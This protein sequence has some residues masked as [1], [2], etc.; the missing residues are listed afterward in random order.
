MALSNPPGMYDGTVAQMNT[1]R[2]RVAAAPLLSRKI[3]IKEIAL[4][5]PRLNLVMD[6]NGRANWAFDQASGKSDAGGA[7]GSSDAAGYVEGVSLAPVVIEDGDIKYLDERTGSV[8]AASGVNLTVSMP[9][10]QSPLKADGSLVWNRERI[11]MTLFVKDPSRLA[12]DGSPVDMTVNGRLLEFIFN[13]RG[14]LRNG[15]SLAGKIDMKTSSLRELAKWSGNPMDT[16]KGLETFSVNGALDLEGESIKLTKARLALD[17]MNAQGN[18]GVSLA[19]AR[20][21]ITANLGADK[22]D[23]NK[24]APP[25]NRGASTGAVSEGW[26]DEPISFV[27]LRA[28]DADLNL[29]VSQINYGDVVIGRTNVKATLKAGVLTATLKEMAFYD[30]KAEGKLVLNGK[31]AKPTLQG[32]LNSTGLDGY[33]LLADFAKLERISGVTGMNL[34]IAA[35]GSSQREMVSTMRGKGKFQ[36]NDGALRGI[37][38]ARMIRSV[39]EN[40]LGGWESKPEE[41]TDFSLLEASFDIKDGIAV[42]KDLKL[43]GPL[44][45]ITGLGEVDLLRQA[46]DYKTNPKLVATLQ[47]QGNESELAGLAVPVIIKGPWSNPKIYPDIEG[48][49][50]N[51]EAAFKALSKLTKAGAG[52]D[53]SK[54]TKGLEKK[55]KKKGLDKVQK[56]AK[57]L[58][59]EDATE[60]LGDSAKQSLDEQ[61]GSLL[62]NLLGG[63]NQGAPDPETI[64]EPEA[65]Q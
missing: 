23:A 14:V 18:I 13:G 16:G 25:A 21:Y 44:V 48:I 33:R 46:L 54:G 9:T 27:G 52:L 10:L 49:L 38:I 26:S 45:R 1:L 59:G 43:I 31:G 51:P 65:T 58:L 19:G 42:N 57:K 8:F 60:L 53:L 34:S 63:G 39:Q 22:I 17:G 56:K 41:K 12:E 2:V 29:A 35:T 64:P 28:L 5:R 61:G 55:L 37:N 62:K 40:I 11:K 47:G 6:S 32:A 7:S 36:F 24:Y 30:G 15:V 20:P 4:V 3:E 50:Q